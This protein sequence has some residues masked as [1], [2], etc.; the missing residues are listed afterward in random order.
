[1]ELRKILIAEESEELSMDLAER[2]RGT[3]LVKICRNAL[4]VNQL[5]R[6]LRP[7]LL[8]LDMTMSGMDGITVLQEAIKEHPLPNVLA[9]TGFAS[10]Y[11][12]DAL[13]RLGVSYVMVKPCDPKALTARILDLAERAEVPAVS[14][15]DRRSMAANL[16][17]SL[18]MPTKLRGY[19][20]TREAI[21]CLMRDPHMSI[22]KE[23]YPKVAELCG[24]TTCQVERVIRSAIIAAW[25]Q[26]D[27]VVWPKY[28]PYDVTGQIPRPTNAAFLTRLADCL[29]MRRDEAWDTCER[30]G[31][32]G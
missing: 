17:I 1:M 18:R 31:T 6:E 30:N 12:L 15:P 27:D 24:G 23:L 5:L 29:S 2:L 26:R 25:N 14:M 16:L 32:D 10:P 8:V 21:L 28:F 9:L 11:V 13:G 3:C 20:C 19:P 4:L 22:T 7:D